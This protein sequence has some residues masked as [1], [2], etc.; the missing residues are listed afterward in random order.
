MNNSLL[1]RYM[2]N[3][4]QMPQKLSEPLTKEINESP[5]SIGIEEIIK[6]KFPTKIV[7]EFIRTQL[8]CI[9]DEN[10]L[11]FKKNIM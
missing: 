10:E 7:R 1:E 11:L 5:N 6:K 8:N 2:P 9:E 4:F 3:L